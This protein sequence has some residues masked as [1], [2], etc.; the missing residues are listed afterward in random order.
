MIISSTNLTKSYKKNSVL[1]GVDLAIEEGK[2]YGL[3]GRNGTGKS[4]LL[5]IIA[6][7]IRH[8]DGDITVFGRKPFDSAKVMDQVVLAGIDTP[9][10]EWWSISKILEV[11]AQRFPHWDA[12]A[13]D[14]LIKEFGL[15]ITTRYGKASRGQRSMVGIIVA[16]AANAPLTLIDEPYLGLDVHNRAIFYREL[17]KSQERNPRTF[18]MATHDLGESAKVIDR[19]LLLGKQGTIDATLD[20]DAV[21]EA[22]VQVDGTDL[23]HAIVDKAHHLEEMGGRTKA[24]LRRVDLAQ[25]L[26]ELPG[27]ARVSNLP[28]EE[29]LGLLLGGGDNGAE[30]PSR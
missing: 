8:N 2:I 12:K 21:D 25:A 11:A 27:N 26:D 19:Y 15:D 29:A 6:G 14:F 30:T 1:N 18:V 20:A 5:A 13:A 9:Y 4:T 24:V 22:F 7:Q 16:L 3:L 10:S 23:P 28:L 17:L